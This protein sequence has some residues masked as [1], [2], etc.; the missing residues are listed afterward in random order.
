[1]DLSERNRRAAVSRWSKIHEKE[2]AS[3]IGPD[4]NYLKARLCGFLAGDGSVSVRRDN[5]GSLHYVLRFFPDHESLIP[6]FEESLMGLYGKS[7]IVKKWTGHNGVICYS[8]TAVM[9]LMCLADFGIRRWRVPF[10]ILTDEK[11]KVEWL[12]AFFD[13]EGYVGK[14]RIRV[15]TVNGKGMDDVGRLLTELGI[16]FGRYSYSP[17]RPGWSKVHIIVISRKSERI[18]FLNTVGFN[19]SLKQSRLV[20]DAQVA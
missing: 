9:D 12:R 19:H 10:N 16:G 18:K 2:R 6:P 4:K 11:S 8:K 5:L 1:M 3:S 13:A 15:Q 7:P 20:S 17:K 14:G